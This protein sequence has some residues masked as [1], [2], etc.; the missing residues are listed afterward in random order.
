MPWLAPH[1]PGS[2][3]ASTSFLSRAASSKRAAVLQCCSAPQPIH[4]AP[5]YSLA[6][7]GGVHARPLQ[8]L[9]RSTSQALLIMGKPGGPV[10]SLLPH[11]CEGLQ[12]LRLFG[13]SLRTSEVINQLRLC[14]SLDCSIHLQGAQGTCQASI[15]LP[16]AA[17]AHGA[18]RES[19]G[20]RAHEH[21]ALRLE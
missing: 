1:L 2:C 15:M 7:H 6:C 14:V 17:A 9:P 21:L 19:Q 11:L 8:P 20:A 12:D 10:G 5:P 16:R 18:T 13:A 3:P 4:N